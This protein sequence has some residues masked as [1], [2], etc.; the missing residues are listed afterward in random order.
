MQLESTHFNKSI[1]AL[2]QV[3]WSIMQLK[4][5]TLLFFLTPSQFALR[6]LS[7]LFLSLCIYIM[8]LYSTKW[9]QNV[10]I[11]KL[12]THIEQ[13]QSIHNQYSWKMEERANQYDG[14]QVY[15]ALLHRNLCWFYQAIQLK[16]MWFYFETIHLQ[17]A[18]SLFSVCVY[19]DISSCLYHFN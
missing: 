9:I 11:H 3:M 4:H 8:N 2:G 17:M 19:A 15:T 14:S 12:E 7:A 13:I 1:S 16:F 18:E 5:K 6:P 10:S